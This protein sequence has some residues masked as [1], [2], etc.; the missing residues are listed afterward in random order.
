MAAATNRTVLRLPPY[1]AELNPIEL[2]WSQI[3]GYVARRNTTFK[4]ADMKQLFC[5]AVGSIT[6]TEW[7]NCVRHVIDVA[8][9]KCWEF[10]GLIDI[11]C[12][13]VIV[14]FSDSDFS[15]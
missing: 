9:K 15:E 13:P 14:T 5:E 3:K 7:Q 12:E 11:I 8:E 1:H 10:D 2:I 6:S 4:M